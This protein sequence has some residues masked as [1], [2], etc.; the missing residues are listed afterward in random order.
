ME[1]AST[2][3]RAENIRVVVHDF[4]FVCLEWMENFFT[5]NHANLAL[6]GTWYSKF[7]AIK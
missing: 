4:G 7:I 6:H 5:F 1:L 3:A 2:F